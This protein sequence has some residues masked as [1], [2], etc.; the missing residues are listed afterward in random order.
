MKV[1]LFCLKPGR[2]SG[3]LPTLTAPHVPHPTPTLYSFM[4]VGSSTS[5]VSGLNSSKCTP[6][7]LSTW[8]KLVM[9]DR[10]C[11]GRERLWRYMVFERWVGYG[12]YDEFYLAP[13]MISS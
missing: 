11:P 3:P 10:V 9:N 7:P 13:K 6:C 4:G 5:V 8:G 1:K 12:K 2:D